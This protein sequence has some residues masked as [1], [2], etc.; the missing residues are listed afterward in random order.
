MA[1][2]TCSPHLVETQLVVKDVLR[3]R[4]DVEVLDTRATVRQVAG[5]DVPLTDRTDVQLWP[6]VHGT[7]AMFVAL[8]RRRA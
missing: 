3:R 8:L 5:P 2:V 6:H 7:D 1:Y 4:D